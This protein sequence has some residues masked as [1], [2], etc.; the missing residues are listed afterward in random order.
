MATEEASSSVPS[1]AP[2]DEK[3]AFLLNHGSFNPVHKHHMDMMIQ[4]KKRLEQAGYKVVGGS[5]AIMNPEFIRRKKE[6]E[7]MTEE[8]RMVALRLACETTQGPFGWLKPDSRGVDFP[9]AGRMIQKLFESEL[10][11]VLVFSVVGAD[12]VVKLCKNGS[13]FNQPMVVVGRAG[14]NNK[15]VRETAENSEAAG[16]QVFYVD[17]LPGVVSSARARE[18]LL[19]DDEKTLR[20]LVPEKAAD[21]LWGNRM[22]LY[23]PEYFEKAILL[24]QAALERKKEAEAKQADEAAEKVEVKQKAEAAGD[25]KGAS[26]GRNGRRRGRGGKLKVDAEEE[27][28]RQIVP[29]SGEG[30]GAGGKPRKAGPTE[31]QKGPAGKGKGSDG[32]DN[33]TSSKGERKGGKME[34]KSEVLSSEPP[35][36]RDG[37]SKGKSGLQDDES[38]GKKGYPDGINGKGKG[39]TEDAGHGESA[40]GKASGKPAIPSWSVEPALVVGVSGAPS[41]GKSSLARDLKYEL[42]G[43]NG[44]NYCFLISQ[45]EFHLGQAAGNSAWVWKDGKW[46]DDWESPDAVDWPALEKAVK[47]ASAKYSVV[48]VEGHCLFSHPHF[49]RL[50]HCLIWLD[51]DEDTCWNRRTAYP[52]GWWQANYWTECLWKGHLRHWEEALGRQRSAPGCGGR[53]ASVGPSRCLGLN[54]S[55]RPSALKERAAKAVLRWAGQGKGK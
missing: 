9:S 28:D 22:D 21:Y 6:A 49:H 23:G 11:G 33:K 55:D 47:D 25:T 36:L 53:S 17:E 35:L 14:S 12:T 16:Y 10:P 43:Q 4:S 39:K 2:T 38:K 13:K 54:G 19:A 48:I 31:E 46:L 42:A 34:A 15:V 1:K 50:L 29:S 5:M 51:A 45:E 37:K 8:H 20:A 30:L 27:D 7:P 26:L 18:A 41:A 52:K 3:L 32:K 40:K 24:R 44:Q